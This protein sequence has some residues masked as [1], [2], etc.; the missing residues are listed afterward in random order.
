MALDFTLQQN[1]TT[2]TAHNVP[3]L[4][5][6]TPFICEEPDSTLYQYFI[7][8][9]G[10]IA[11]EKKTTV[12]LGQYD[13]LPWADLQN[14]LSISPVSRIGIKHFPHIGAIG[15]YKDKYTGLPMIAA[16]I[17]VKTT[18]YTAPVIDIVTNTS[19]VTITITPPEDVSYTC[20]KVIMR[21]GYFAYEYVTYETPVEL[22]LPAVIG[23]YTIYAVGYNET[24]GICSMS[25][26]I[27]S[28]TISTGRSSWDPDK[29]VVPMALAELVDVNLVDLLNAQQL[30]YNSVS[31]K[32]EN[33]CVGDVF[34]VTLEVG[35]W[36]GSA[37]PYEQTIALAG[38]V[39]SGYSYIVT[40]DD[41]SW[42]SYGAGGIYMK[43][44]TTDGSITFI[45][46]SAM[47]AVA[48][49]VNILKVRAS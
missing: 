15:F 19:S 28:L 34:T 38:I 29:L 11:Q 13:D 25:S 3:P 40:P 20:Y 37:V 33:A 46:T 21:S 41:D 12:L 1:L 18:K 5:V 22:P 4:L 14:Q 42:Y 2:D 9:N 47:P 16:P 27:E 8:P 10:D 23:T 26:N 39:A 7:E 31:G 43:D 48:L 45:A 6:K 36:T 49:T 44:P 32:W 30:K 35:N 17:H 24:T